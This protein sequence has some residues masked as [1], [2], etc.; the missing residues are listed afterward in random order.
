MKSEYNFGSPY[1]YGYNYR[2]VY[3]PFFYLNNP[4]FENEFAT[5]NVRNSFGVFNA[6]TV[7]KGK[8][9]MRRDYYRYLDEV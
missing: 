5:S 9:S 8:S 2:Y 1:N 6:M 4:T 7:L 3:F